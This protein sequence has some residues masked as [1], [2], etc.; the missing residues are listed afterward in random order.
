MKVKEKKDYSNLRL[1]IFIVGLFIFL[2]YLIIIVEY[3]N[4]EA[5]KG[6]IT[7]DIKKNEKIISFRPESDTLIIGLI[8]S[9]VP[10]YDRYVFLIKEGTEYES[11]YVKKTK[12]YRKDEEPHHIEY[13]KNIIV[14]EVPKQDDELILPE[15][16]KIIKVT[17]KQM[18]S[19]VRNNRE[20]LIIRQINNV[21]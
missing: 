17:D 1:G 14:K 19:I 20:N 9:P 3:K 4:R 12:I 11:V 15:K 2:I 5:E 6:K 10:R 13:H 16:S 21:K 18:D 8:S 7:R